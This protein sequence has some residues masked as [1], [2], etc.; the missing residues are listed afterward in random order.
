MQLLSII[1]QHPVEL[2]IGVYSLIN[3][4]I[5]LRAAPTPQE[6]CT[7]ELYFDQNGAYP[8][9]QTSG[10]PAGV[11]VDLLRK[12]LVEITA[13]RRTRRL[14]ICPLESSA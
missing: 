2:L 12:R 14:S 13:K 7:I 10:T 5:A 6:R 1:G 3:L 4:V 8:T 9:S 11:R